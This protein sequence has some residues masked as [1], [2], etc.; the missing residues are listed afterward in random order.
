MNRR[1]I[2]GVP[3]ELSRRVRSG[4]NRNSGS[5]RPRKLA[6]LVI[7]LSAAGTAWSVLSEYSLEITPP[8]AVAGT[9]PS[10]SELKGKVIYGK[11]DRKDLWEEPDL[12]LL[13]AASSTVA[14]VRSQDLEQLSNGDVLLRQTN[15][16]KSYGLC[17]EERFAEQNIGAFCSGF[18]VQPDTIVTAG[19]CVYDALACETTSFVFGYAY[20]SPLTAPQTVPADD[21]Y[22]CAEVVFAQSWTGG[23]DYSVVRLDRPVKNRKPLALRRSGQLQVAED[24][25]VIGHPAGLPT[26]IAAGAK[27]RSTA[28]DAYFVANLDT[29]GGNSGSAVF[30]AKTMEVEGILVRGEADFRRSPKG[31]AVSIVCADDA[32]RGEDVTRISEVLPYLAP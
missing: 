30:N 26:K 20:H 15:Y 10:S 14:V 6:L 7:L 8:T 32:C 12:R 5:S 13:S 28:P 31:C 23:A 18:L 11:D 21:V 29:Y 24:L 9:L 17:P 19:H 22:K 16:G 3:V 1:R 2:T 25:V 27:V 4:S